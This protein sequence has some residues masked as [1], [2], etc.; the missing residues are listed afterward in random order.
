MM[1]R[2]STTE[3]RCGVIC[4]RS[5]CGEVV[6]LILKTAAVAFFGATG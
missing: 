6:E 4:L 5:C 2:N 1:L 3:H